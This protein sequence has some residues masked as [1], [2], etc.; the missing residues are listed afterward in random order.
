MSPIQP[1]S[2]KMP[3]LGGSWSLLAG[4]CAVGLR[5]GLFGLRPEDEGVRNGEAAAFDPALGAIDIQFH[6]EHAW[7]GNHKG[8]AGTEK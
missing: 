2:V 8:A 5:G 1:S 7:R 6:P 4:L 3:F